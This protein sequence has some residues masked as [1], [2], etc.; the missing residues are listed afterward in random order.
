LAPAVL[1]AA[2]SDLTFT[3]DPLGATL[4]TE[5]A[6]AVSAG[7][8]TAPKLAG[9]FDLTLLNQV[10]KSKGLPEVSST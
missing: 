6:H 3:I 10:L 4:Q 7:L 2:W 5:A 9:I 8:L 1:S